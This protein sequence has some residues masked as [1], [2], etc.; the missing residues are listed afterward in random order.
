[1]NVL[2]WTIAGLAVVSVLVWGAQVAT[3]LAYTYALY[4]NLLAYA[5]YGVVR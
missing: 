2:M 5:S 3:A 4:F 1:M